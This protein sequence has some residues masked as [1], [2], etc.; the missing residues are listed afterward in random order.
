MAPPSVSKHTLEG[1]QLGSAQEA[2]VKLVASR[3]LAHACG[4]AGEDEVA[5]EQRRERRDVAQLEGHVEYHL[6]QAHSPRCTALG[7]R[8]PA[9][10]ALGVRARAASVRAVRAL[11]RAQ[12]PGPPSPN[13]V[14]DRGVCSG[15]RTRGAR[16]VHMEGG[17]TPLAH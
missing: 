16:V 1:R 13:H 7:A 15:G 9:H 14:A 12:R 4:G 3:Q 8:R 2:Q 6:R 17:G 10:G 11:L 5:G